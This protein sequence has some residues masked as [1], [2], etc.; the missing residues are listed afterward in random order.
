MQRW[1][2]TAQKTSSGKPIDVLLC[3]AAPVQGTPHD[4]KPWWGY[5]SQWN[6]L[7]YPSGILPAG[8]V[9]KTDA[10]P[11]NFAPVNELDKENYDLCR[12]RRPIL[13]NNAQ[14]NQSR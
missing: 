11:A 3:P 6:L 4:V 5:S 10:Y 13:L 9:L 14:L 7:D 12:S 2:D 1:N 8:K